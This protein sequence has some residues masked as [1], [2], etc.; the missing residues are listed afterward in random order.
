MIYSAKGKFLFVHISRCAGTL[1]SNNLYQ[2]F[3]D[4]K[5]IGIQHSPCAT[6]LPILKSEFDQVYKFCVVRN[7]W[8][9]LVSWFELVSSTP[10]SGINN[11]NHNTLN[12]T[13]FINHWLNETMDIQGTT[14]PTQSQF[15]MITDFDN[16]VLVDHVCRF[17]NLN[18]ELSKMGE[19]L[20][21]EFQLNQKINASSKLHYS[22]YYNNETKAKVEEVCHQDITH[23]GFK[24][25]DCRD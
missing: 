6:A 13:Q 11:S 2:H 21:I 16:K 24:F 12:F 1:I 8:E 5:Q 4:S 15:A 22:L 14:K 17:E 9:R 18:D 25:D 19:R 10:S 3:S 7:P 20:N 23:F